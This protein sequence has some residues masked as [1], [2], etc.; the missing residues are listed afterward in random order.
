MAKP[1]FP[2]STAWRAFQVRPTNDSTAKWARNHPRA[3]VANDHQECLLALALAKAAGGI[4]VIAILRT[5]GMSRNDFEKYQCNQC[6]HLFARGEQLTAKVAQWGRSDVTCMLGSFSEDDLSPPLS[7]TSSFPTKILVAGSEEPRKGFADLIE[8]VKL[9]E[10]VEPDFPAIEFTCTGDMTEALDELTNQPLRSSFTF[11]G[12]VENFSAYA[13]SFHLAIHPSRSESF[14][15]APLELL[16]AGV[17]TMISSTGITPE[18]PMSVP[19]IF[20]PE[21]PQILSQA[22]CELWKNWPIHQLNL[23]D[24]QHHILDHFHISFTATS[25]T[26]ALKP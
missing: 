2:R 21:S 1:T 18:L 16:L 3:I 11:I 10:Q 8:A 6:D 15:M 13:R 25:L 26:Q 19:W 4:P 5:P 23:N 14:G 20:P 22:I 24:I 9:V 12:R 17:P 7:H